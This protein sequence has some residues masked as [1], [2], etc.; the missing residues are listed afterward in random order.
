[1]VNLIERLQI[2]I[3]RHHR[4]LLFIDEHSWIHSL[5]IIAINKRL[6]VSVDGAVDVLVIEW[7]LRLISCIIYNLGVISNST[8]ILLLLF[9]ISLA[10]LNQII[11]T[12][13]LYSASSFVV[14]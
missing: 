2:V 11:T 4:L 9:N 14:F 10:L 8:S 12:E 5:F 1:M 13:K 7:E 3:I 6:L